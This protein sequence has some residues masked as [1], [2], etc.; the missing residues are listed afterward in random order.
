MKVH[1]E[2]HI[3]DVMAVRPKIRKGKADG[4]LVG[5]FKG[6]EQN[7][8][9]IAASSAELDCLRKKMDSSCKGCGPIMRFPKMQRLIRRVSGH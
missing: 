6:P 2:R 7:A 1:E 4:V 5:P 3:A 8:T 9:E